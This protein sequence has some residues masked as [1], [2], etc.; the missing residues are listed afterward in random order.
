VTPSIP[1]VT[2]TDALSNPATGEVLFEVTLR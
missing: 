2:S 1:G